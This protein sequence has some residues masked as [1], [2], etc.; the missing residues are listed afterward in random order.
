[1]CTRLTLLSVAV[2]SA[3]GCFV[4][5]MS[6]EYLKRRVCIIITVTMVRVLEQRGIRYVTVDEFVSQINWMRNDKEFINYF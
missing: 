6:G 5:F 2:A 1:M 3:E 4:E